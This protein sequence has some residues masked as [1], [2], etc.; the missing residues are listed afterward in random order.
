MSGTIIER[1]IRRCN[2]NLFLVNV[3]VIALVLLWVILGQ[4]YLYNCAAGPFPIAAADF[5]F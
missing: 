4:R 3:G 1:Q 5:Q 2:R